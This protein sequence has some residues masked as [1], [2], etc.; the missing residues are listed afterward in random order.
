MNKP[1]KID[2]TEETLEEISAEDAEDAL[3]WKREQAMQL[4]MGLGINAYNDAM[5]CELELDRDW[6]DR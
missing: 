6:R 1:S 4:G 5:G 2:N 3:E